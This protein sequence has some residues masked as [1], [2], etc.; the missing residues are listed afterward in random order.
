MRRLPPIPLIAASKG[1]EDVWRLNLFFFFCFNHF[2]LTLYFCI[3]V[4]T[5]DSRLGDLVL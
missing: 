4:R 5:E 1:D 2:L 3:N